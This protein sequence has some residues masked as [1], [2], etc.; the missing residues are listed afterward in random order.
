VAKV[1]LLL[2]LPISMSLLLLIPC[3]SVANA[4]VSAFSRVRPWQMLLLL[5]GLFKLNPCSS[6][7]A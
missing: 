2:F 1:F 7:I 5:L 3:S 4:F 6:Q